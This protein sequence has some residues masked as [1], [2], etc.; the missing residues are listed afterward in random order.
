MKIKVC[1]LAIFLLIVICTGCEDPF[2]YVGQLGDVTDQVELL[3]NP[4]K[5]Q[6]LDG[7]S[8]V[9]ARNIW[10][11]HAFKGKIY[12][13]GGNSS[14]DP[15]ASNAVPVYMWSYSPKSGFIREFRTNDCQIHLIR[16]FDGE[17]YLPGHDAS[18]G[19][20]NGVHEWDLGNFYRL[21]KLTNKWVKYRNIPFAIHVYDVYKW[22]NKLFASIGPNTRSVADSTGPKGDPN[23]TALQVSHDNGLSWEYM[24]I[25]GSTYPPRGRIYNIFPLNGNLYITASYFAHYSGSSNILYQHTYNETRNFGTTR[26]ERAVVLDDYTVFI[27]GGASNDHQYIPGNLRSAKN[28]LSSTILKLPSGAVPRD[29]MVRDGYLYALVTYKN[30]NDCYKNAV[31]VTWSVASADVEWLE[32]FH[33]TKSTFARSFEYMDDSFYFGLGC[34]VWPGG[35]NDSA[36]PTYLHETGNILRYVH[37]GHM[38]NG[39]TR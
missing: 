30:A 16:E 8:K 29:L 20:V 19:T 21:N 26:V 5:A 35:E 9:Y 31:L 37:T 6:Y 14:N 7:T 27:D 38:S 13:G 23:A 34:D 36:P 17:L 28:A 11:M 33:F 15:P 22:G 24:Q 10:D 1:M 3:D 2:D 39:V 25:S 18:D 4:L 32:L 12:F